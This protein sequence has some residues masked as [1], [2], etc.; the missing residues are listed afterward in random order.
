MRKALIAL[1]VVAILIAIMPFGLGVYTEHY[2]RNLL[3]NA[4]LPQGIYV[5]LIDYQR[6]YLRSQATY[7]INLFEVNP[8]SDAIPEKIISTQTHDEIQHGPFFLNAPYLAVAQIHSYVTANDLNLPEEEKEGIDQLFV[9]E[10][11]LQA[12]T[13]I[14]FNRSFHINMHSSGISHQQPDG[15]FQWGGFDSE[16]KLTGDLYKAFLSVDIAPLLLQANDNTIM[17]F[18]RI[19]FVFDAK[20]TETS[21]WTGQQ[22]LSIPGFFFE[23]KEG[24]QL[25][26]E[27]FLLSADSSAKQNISNF[28]INLSA[29]SIEILSQV[30][31]DLQIKAIFNRLDSLS[32]LSIAQITQEDDTISP[33]EKRALSQDIIYL[34]TPGSEIKLDGAAELNTGNIKGNITIIFPDVSAMVTDESPD[35]I[36]QNLTSMLE[37]ELSYSVPMSTFEEIFYITASQGV[38]ADATVVVNEETGETKLV[39]DL[40]RQSI[41]E[42][43]VLLNQNDIL[44]SD[45]TNYTMHLGYD[46]GAIILNGSRLEP[47][48]LEHIMSIIKSQPTSP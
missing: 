24:N 17:D 13:F 41:H 40:I 42:E 9:E 45:G 33:N 10:K 21:P 34:F 30:I 3:A 15:N 8:G 16:L 2:I 26:L 35:I 32:L 14:Y 38:P 39:R 5:E 47:E 46:R 4:P 12:N 7:E 25:R 44:L 48:D 22:N 43:I 31:K 11:I 37:A 23:D 19:T 18:S 28:D 27:S 29:K 1:L 36:A 6:G 20:R